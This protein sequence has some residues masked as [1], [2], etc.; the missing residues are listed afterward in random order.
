M[1]EIFLAAPLRTEEEQRMYWA[2]RWALE[3]YVTRVLTIGIDVKPMYPEEISKLEWEYISK[4]DALVAIVPRRWQVNGFLYTYSVNE[5]I[6]YAYQLG[7]PVYLFIEEGVLREG[8]IEI[9]ADYVWEFERDM[10]LGENNLPYIMKWIS[11][12]VIHRI[13]GKILEEWKETCLGLG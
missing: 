8:G 5:E 6:S 12:D 9:K 3:P 11:D 13:K 1:A 2:F 4:S 7:K 10:I